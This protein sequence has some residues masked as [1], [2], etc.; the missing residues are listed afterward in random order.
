MNVAAAR[1]WGQHVRSLRERQGWNVRY[2]AQQTGVSVGTI[3]NIENGKGTNAKLG[4]LLALQ[5]LFELDSLEALFGEP[6]SAVLAG[7]QVVRRRGGH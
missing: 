6:V 4:N 2:V 3:S 7:V 5:E 1:A